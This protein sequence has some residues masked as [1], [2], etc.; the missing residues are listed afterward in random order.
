MCSASQNPQAV[1][2]LCLTHCIY[3]PP[4]FI[5]PLAGKHSRYT[6]HC[7]CQPGRSKFM[8]EEF[9]TD[10]SAGPVPHKSECQREGTG[11]GER[12]PCAGSML[13]HVCCIPSVAARPLHTVC[14][15]TSVLLFPTPLLNPIVCTDIVV[16]RR[17]TVQS[18]SWSELP[19][20]ARKTEKPRR[21]HS[22]NLL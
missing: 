7:A 19:R 17:P 18:D 5:L 14:C 3:I 12:E 20:R 10:K 2:I 11:S 22:K 15:R 1:Q 21:T 4:C 13:H 6:Q 16:R 9:Q 8:M